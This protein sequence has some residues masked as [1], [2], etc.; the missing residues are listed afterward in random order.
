MNEIIREIRFEY[1]KTKKPKDIFNEYTLML[2]ALEKTETEMLKSIST[3]LQYKSSLESIETGSI[4]A[5]IK[6]WMEDDEPNL[7]NEKLGNLDFKNYLSD[8]IKTIVNN[9]SQDKNITANTIDKISSDLN[10]LAEQYKI[11]DAFSYAPIQKKNL[12]EISNSIREATSNLSNDE[13]VYL[14][15][16]NGSSIELPKKI[17]IQVS[18]KDINSKERIIENE[19]EQILRIKKPDYIADSAWEFK[20]GR[21]VIN[22]KIEDTN[23]INQFLNKE[24]KLYPGDSL[25]C[26]VFTV[27]EYDKLGTLVTSKVSITKV[28]EIIE[29]NEKDV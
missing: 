20:I 12:I 4:V 10:N 2:I 27:E 5:K 8:G 15:E 29:G 16:E 6:S 23:W 25:R 11:T 17:N 28:L 1:S 22:I 9:L 21:K 13:N 3:S 14:L 7:G 24:I 18:E 26:K 19:I